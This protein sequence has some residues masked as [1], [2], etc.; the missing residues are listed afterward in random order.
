VDSLERE[1]KLSDRTT[2]V[3]A[4]M[5]AAETLNA[6]EIV[7]ASKSEALANKVYAICS[8]RKFNGEPVHPQKAKAEFLSLAQ[9]LDFGEMLKL[10]L[11]FGKLTSDSFSAELKNDLAA[12]S[13]ESQP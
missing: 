12:L 4:P 6:D 11:E 13:Y 1:I 9:R 5:T 10:G 7:G 8:V 2:V 3:I